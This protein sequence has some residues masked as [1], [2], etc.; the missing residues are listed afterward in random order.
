[1]QKEKSTTPRMLQATCQRS[2]LEL[3]SYPYSSLSLGV[4]GPVASKA[5]G[6]NRKGKNFM[7]RVNV[8]VGSGQDKTAERWYCIS[9]EIRGVKGAY[10]RGIEMVD[11]REWKQ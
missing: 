8:G 11:H 9:T 3:Q 7:K 6:L 4:W 2:A 1:M 10:R 5:Q